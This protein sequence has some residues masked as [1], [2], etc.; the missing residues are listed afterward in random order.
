FEVLVICPDLE[1]MTC[2]HEKMTP[3]S[4]GSHNGKELAIVDLIVTF[5]GGKGFREECYRVPNSLLTLRENSTECV[6]GAVR[7]KAIWVIIGG[8]R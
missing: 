3:F 8:D 2:S 4:Q 1:R 7:F 5:G 6:A